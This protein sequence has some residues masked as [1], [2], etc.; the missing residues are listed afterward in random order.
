MILGALSS[1]QRY[2]QLHPFFQRAFETLCDPKIASMPAG[3]HAIDGEQLALIIGHDPGR[4]RDGSTLECHRKYLDIQCTLEGRDEVGWSPLAECRDVQ[5][6]YDAQRD[7]A[8]YR[9]RPRAWIP[10]AVGDFMILYPED[11]HAPLAGTGPLV[12]AVMKVA[13]KS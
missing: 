11:A 9:D 1:A 5:L 3:R 7:L 8:L 4:G 13:I 12:K 10:L 6:E 2:F